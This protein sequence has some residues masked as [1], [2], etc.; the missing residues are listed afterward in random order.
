MFVNENRL[1]HLLRPDQY[2]SERQYQLE[3]ER[4]LRPAW[5]A[6]G[7]KADIPRPGDYFTFELLGQPLLV[8]NI[9]GEVHTFLNVCAHRH[10]LLTDKPKGH[11]PRFRCQ[12]HGWEYQKDGR[13]GHVPEARHFKPWDREN[14]RL[15]KFRSALCGEMIFVSLA[16]VGPSLQEH[17]DPWWERGQAYFDGKTYRLAWKYDA[18]YA[19]NWKVPLENSLESYHVPCLHQATFGDLPPEEKC[20]HDLDPRYTTF[21]TVEIDNFA[22]R[23]GRWAVRR[24]G[25][26]PTGVYIN[27]HIHP[28]VTF[29]S[30]DVF[31]FCQLFIP[32]SPA[33][34]RHLGWLY[35]IRGT[36]RGPLAWLLARF[37]RP[38]ITSVTHKV[39]RE[40]VGIFEQV[41]RGMVASPHAGVFGIR[42]ERLFV[43]QEYVA[44]LVGDPPVE[45]APVGA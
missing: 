2:H 15:K 30:L 41:Q 21:R 45:N 27:H 8:R 23:F 34:C 25:L 22:T 12:Y 20:E 4:V 38:I 42:E 16:D 44:R 1:C 9:D 13:T 29:T 7:S 32:T 17:L 26:T 5:H 33:T 36:R 6:V 19:T 40:D 14:A 31:R 37:L 3:L 43:F 18:T 35:T 28:T 11:D 10:C 24:M 39:V